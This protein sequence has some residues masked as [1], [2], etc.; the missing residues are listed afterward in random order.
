MIDSDG[1]TTSCR[2]ASGFIPPADVPEKTGEGDSDSDSDG[3]DATA[4]PTTTVK[5]R[6]ALACSDGE[7]DEELLEDD[8]ALS[9]AERHARP[10]SEPESDAG[11][12]A[13]NP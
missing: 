10:E 6:A 9:L 13:G 2:L 11:A 7:S 8:R 3:G 4:G 5:P 12:D 1:T